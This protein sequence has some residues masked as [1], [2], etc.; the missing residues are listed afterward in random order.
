MKWLI[1]SAE[2]RDLLVDLVSI[3]SVNPSLVPGGAG[4][5]N[6]AKRIAEYTKAWGFPTRIDYITPT[7]PNV[8]AVLGGKIAGEQALD[9]RHGFMINGHIDVVG[10]QGMTDP[11]K[12]R[13]EGDRVYGRGASDMKNGVVAGLLAMKAIQ[14]SGIK[15]AK[16]VLFTG[17]AD[18][19]YASIGTE[20][21]AKHYDADA[22]LIMEGGPLPTV[23]HKGF[24]WI[25]VET[26]GNAV[27]GS[28]YA[29]GIDAIAM[30]GRFLARVDALNEGY[31]KD[32]PHP[33]RG[34]KSI[35]ASLVRGGK[36][37]ST[38]PDHCHAEFERRTL[39]KEDPASI[40]D[41]FSTIIAGLRAEDPRFN[42]KVTLDFVRWGY[43][44]DPDHTL[45]ENLREAIRDNYGE[46]LPVRGASGWMDSAVLGAKGIPTAI[47][48]IGGHGGH[49]LVEWSE[50]S[51]LVRYA[52]VV[53]D[54]IVKV[55]GTQP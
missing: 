1:D 31:A 15:L 9:Q 32:V 39:P 33:L 48:G 23:S 36:E 4:E 19:E 50:I 20:D 34:R 8:V 29:Q 30:M 26:F 49:D 25:T 46:D 3:D 24:A 37:L 45:V 27:H 10:V 11:F 51:R 2:A 47:F 5:E 6:V 16:S 14:E 17:V 53:A 43:E 55:C 28:N 21:I 44:I 13:V 42:A 35:H 38:Y 12:P 41:E 7:R 18:E 52:R 22:A 54:L 40:V